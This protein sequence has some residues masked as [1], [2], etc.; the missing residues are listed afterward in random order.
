MRGNSQGQMS[1]KQTA[2]QLWQMSPLRLES[3]HR[4]AAVPDRPQQLLTRD[5][6]EHPTET[7]ARNLLGK[8]L[9]RRSGKKQWIGGIIVETEAYLKVGDAS[10]HAHAGRTRRSEIMFAEA[11]RL[12]VY[13]IH[14]KYCLNV[15]TE[16]QHEGCAVLIRALQPVWGIAKM[17]DHR[18]QQELRKLCSG[19]AMLCQALN[20]DTELNGI[21]LIQAETVAIYDLSISHESIPVVAT[22]RIGISR[23]IDLPLR[24]FVDRNHFVSGRRREHSDAANQQFV[25]TGSLHGDQP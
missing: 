1:G 13:A 23:A 7:V 16:Q 21:D 8:G 19:P 2:K 20:V 17:Q 18:G 15:V 24:F 25:A 9:L 4:H 3:S 6:Y 14:A 10:C 22:Q 5:F 12:Y 11:G